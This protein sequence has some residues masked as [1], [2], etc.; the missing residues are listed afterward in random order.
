M[1]HPAVQEAAVVSIPHEKWD[2]RPAA[3]VVLKPG[4]NATPEELRQYLA[5]QF[6]SFWLPD[7]FVF[8]DTLPRNA[9]GKCLKSALRTQLREGARPT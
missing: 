5:P 9:T 7:T 4:A 1:G 8:M 6:A 3:C 2:E